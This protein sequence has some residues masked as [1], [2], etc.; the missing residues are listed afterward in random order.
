MTHSVTR[1]HRSKAHD[2]VLRY[3]ISIVYPNVFYV[4][5][6]VYNYRSAVVTIVLEMNLQIVHNL[7]IRLVKRI[8]VNEGKTVSLVWPIFFYKIIQS[9]LIER[10]EWS[11]LC[12]S[13]TMYSLMVFFVLPFETRTNGIIVQVFRYVTLLW[14][15]SENCLLLRKTKRYADL[16]LSFADDRYRCFSDIAFI[17]LLRMKRRAFDNA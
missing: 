8:T 10:I 4:S 2:I 9:V 3:R 5:V 13:T 7:F 1:F 15:F 17:R 6:R 14:K 12:L 16:F 11:L